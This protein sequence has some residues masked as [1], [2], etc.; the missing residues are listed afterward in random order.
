MTYSRL[1]HVPPRR[2]GSVAVLDLSAVWM[3]DDFPD[4]HPGCSQSADCRPREGNPRT[5]TSKWMGSPDDLA[6]I[7]TPTQQFHS[8]VGAV[9]VGPWVLNFSGRAGQTSVNAR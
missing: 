5:R 7:S 6:C 9:N 2:G 1:R 3:A 8:R 4:D